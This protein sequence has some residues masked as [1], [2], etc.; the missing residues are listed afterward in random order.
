[1]VQLLRARI[2]LISK[3][4]EAFDHYR[5]A[6]DSLHEVL[7][8]HPQLNTLRTSLI[9][10]YLNSSLVTSGDYRSTESLK[11]LTQASE[12]ISQLEDPQSPLSQLQQAKILLILAQQNTTEG[13]VELVKK[14]LNSLKKIQQ[15]TSLPIDLLA[16]IKSLQ[17]FLYW[18]QGYLTK[19]INTL[20][21][22]L[23][24]LENHLIDSPKD[25]ELLYRKASILWERSTMQTRFDLSFKDALLASE[26]IESIFQ[27]PLSGQYKF[28]LSKSLAILYADLAYLCC[29]LYT[30]P[31]PRDA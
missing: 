5:Q 11:L 3:P 30:S 31:S 18:D 24:S 1:M 7:N 28:N 23:E 9:Q 15:T 16:G 13:N 22:S 4:H 19:A 6:I 25:L 21:S 10:A 12:E 26:V 8:L 29:L 17:A 2:T 20:T 14:Q 27:S